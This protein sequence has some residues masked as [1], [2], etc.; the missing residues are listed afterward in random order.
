MN[1]F[2][3]DNYRAKASA[4][5]S[6]W[7]NRSGSAE[8]KIRRKTISTTIDHA[9]SVFIT[10][11]IVCPEQWF[12]QSIRPLFLLKEAYG[13]SSDWDL[14]RDHLLTD[15]PAGKMWQRISLWTKG[16][17]STTREQ[18][19]PYTPDDPALTHYGNPYLR[20]IAAV[21]IRKSG[22]QTSSDL[23][24]ISAYAKF[25]RE[26]LLRQLELCDPTVIVCGYTGFMLDLIAQPPV[27][28]NPNAS[29]I[30]H[31]T[32][33]GHDV[34]VLDFWHP[35]N[36]YPDLMNYYTIMALYQQALREQDSLKKNKTSP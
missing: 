27:R 3:P 30:Y 1:P 15:G 9:S 8:L 2:T 21:N 31:W 4:L 12:S 20:Q 34:L 6:Q 7:K 32:L 10:D 19:A 36:Q 13:G 24:T 26:F 23:D 11:G 14:C 5:F 35:A 18:L 25:D 17:L 22:G 28:T 29:G 33:N 16:L